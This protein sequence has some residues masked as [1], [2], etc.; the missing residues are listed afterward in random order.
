MEIYSKSLILTLFMPSV[1]GQIIHCTS[2]PVVGTS[3]CCSTSSAVSSSDAYMP[4]TSNFQFRCCGVTK[5]VQVDGGGS[6][7]LTL[8]VWR[9]YSNTNYTL[10]GNQQITVT[11]GTSTIPDIQRL[12]FVY[13]DYMGWSGTTLVRYNTYTDSGYVLNHKTATPSVSVGG[14]Y[15][16]GSADVES[17]RN[18]GIQVITEE[19]TAPYFKNLPMTVTIA[20]VT[21]ITSGVTIFTVSASDVDPY[22]VS[23]LTIEPYQYKDDY[24]TFDKSSNTVRSARQLLADSSYTMV[25]VVIESHCLKTSTATLTVIIQNSKPKITSLPASISIR[26]SVYQQTLLHTLTVTD[27][28]NDYVTCSETW[29]VGPESTGD[30]KYPFIVRQIS[31]SSSAYGIYLMAWPQLDYNSASIYNLSVSCTDGTNTVTGIFYVNVIENSKPI[32]ANLDNVA[33]VNATTAF[34]GKVL[35]TVQT[36]DEESDQRTLSHTCNPTGCPFYVYDSGE[37]S[38]TSNLLRWS[39]SSYDLTVSANDGYTTIPSE[40]LKVYIVG[41]NNDPI[42]TNVAST[43]LSVAENTALGTSLYTVSATDADYD[44]ITFYMAVTPDEG[45]YLFQMDS[46][47]G[48]IRTHSTHAINYDTLTNKAFTMRVY[49]YDG[50]WYD[51]E[52]ITIS[53]TSV[54]EAPSFNQKAY[55]INDYEGASGTV[56]QNPRFTTIDPDS[57][58]TL[59]YSHNCG[60]DTSRFTINPS[61]GRL[62]Y[63]GSYSLDMGAPKSVTCSITATDSGGLTGVASLSIKVGYA[64]QFTPVFDAPSYSFTISQSTPIGNVAFQINATDSVG[65]SQGIVEYALNQAS[66]GNTYF[67]ILKNGTAYVYRDLT[68]FYTGATYT[69]TATARD[70]L[71]LSSTVNVVIIFPVSTTTIT[72]T[73]DREKLFFQDYRNMYWLVPSGL[74]AAVL[75]FLL[76]F[77]VI[78]CHR[79]EDKNNPRGWICCSD[80]REPIQNRNKDANRNRLNE[81]NDEV[82]PKTTIEEREERYGKNNRLS[83]TDEEHDDEVRNINSRVSLV[84]S[85]TANQNGGERNAADWTNNS[86]SPL[87][88]RRA[89]IFRASPRFPNN[90]YGKPTKAFPTLFQQVSPMPL[91]TPDSLRSTVLDIGL[92]NQDTGTSDVFLANP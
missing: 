86:P 89:D 83:I 64:N 52:T 5:S 29:T 66:M 36:Y 6:G 38:I 23:G 55:S 8:S 44:N 65:D 7:L 56:L 50:I 63:N 10:I 69:I 1:L 53:V 34:T 79:I 37:V 11:G 28:V 39:T 21:V 13:G 72:S 67:A 51:V 41:V 88:V 62:S 80:T 9:R 60:N 4:E 73:T 84:A 19:S 48:L 45:W 17:N 2:N 57:G 49:A 12:S 59:T 15:D 90:D 77:M 92:D 16:W 85:P 31:A 76:V 81:L 3:G 78:R 75:L 71:G 87:T 33:I 91:R 42:I 32:I 54:N 30:S 82:K 58:D 74:G 61:T 35:M 27:P 25:F 20:D 40:K 46:T 22:D 43:S 24:F 18:Y 70:V 47:S 68:V 14:S 26:E